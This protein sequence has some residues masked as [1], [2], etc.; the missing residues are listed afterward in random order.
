LQM[1]SALKMRIAPSV[2]LSL[3]L[4][5][6]NGAKFTKNFRL[7]F[8]ANA[9]AE[10]EER[11]GFN[12]LRGEIWEKLSFKNL[13]I[14]FWACALA[15]HDEYDSEEGLRVVRSYMDL[16]NTEKISAAV[17]KAFMLGLPEE[18][19]KAIEAEQARKDS[20]K[21]PLESAGETPAATTELP[22]ANS[23]PQPASGSDS[24]EKNSAA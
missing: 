17:Q 20:G 5:E 24:A 9:A 13:S 23:G 10:V 14:M 8:D 22:G 18:K 11:T 21:R 7:S 4:E 6:D 3:Q 1:Q 12:M 19:R 2:P 16:S 15:N